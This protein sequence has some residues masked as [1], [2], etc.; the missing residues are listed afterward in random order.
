MGHIKSLHV[1]LGILSEG[2]PRCEDQAVHRIQRVTALPSLHQASKQ[3][4]RWDRMAQMI[5]EDK[6]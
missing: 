6:L 1:Q 5:E 3:Y 2:E 4:N